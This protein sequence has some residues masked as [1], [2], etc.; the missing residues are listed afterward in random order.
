[1]RR[2]CV[3]PPQDDFVGGS[4]DAAEEAEGT[5]TFKHLCATLIQQAHLAPL[6]LQ[7]APVYWEWD[8][9]LYLYPAPH[10][11]ALADRTLPQTQYVFEG[12]LF[13]NMVRAP[14][15]GARLR[16]LAAGAGADGIGPRVRRALSAR[17]DRLRSTAPPRVRWSSRACRWRK[18]TSKKIP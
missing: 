14:P 6:P 8:H 15:R 9:A 3:R 1:M 2:G 16:R 13:F 11:V 18:K 10:V 17:M 4:G 12:T 7:H 5:K